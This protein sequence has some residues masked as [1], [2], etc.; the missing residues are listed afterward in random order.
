MQDEY[1][2]TVETDDDGFQCV[3]FNLPLDASE[4][5]IEYLR[6]LVL[7]TDAGLLVLLDPDTNEVVFILRPVILH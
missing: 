3:S 7:C 2:A 4:E 1:C 6:S 5:E